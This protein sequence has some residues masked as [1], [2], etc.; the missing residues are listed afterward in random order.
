[1]NKQ[2][3]ILIIRFSAMGD[4]VLTVPVI[5]SFAAANPEAKIT[6]LTKP[7][8]HPFFD[9]IPNINLPIVELK[10]KHKGILGLR[11]LVRESHQKQRFDAII[12]LH[13]VLRTWVIGFFFRLKG[14]PVFKIDKG[15]KAKKAFLQ[16]ITTQKLPH[17]TER[18]HRVFKQAGYVFPLE[19]QQL[20]P[21]S[22][23][24]LNILN[25]TQI[26]IGLAP[27][28]AHKSKEWGLENF[29]QL[30]QQLNEEHNIQFYL[31]GGG[32][33]EVD[34]LNQFASSYK[35]VYNL[36]GKYNL[37]EEMQIISRLNLM[38]CMDSGNMHI[39]TLTGIPVISIWGGTHPN[40]GFSALY[41]PE[42][43]SI[44]PSQE[45]QQKCLYSVFGTSKPQLDESPYFC[46][47]KIKP[48]QVI[49][50]ILEIGSF[51]K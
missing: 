24:P 42:A 2:S 46:I 4:V 47:K 13:S 32:A 41:Q 28:T 6:V 31:F 18:Y 29:H 23:T 39:A 40:V 3:S 20:T 8:F 25:S 9:G 43:N 26:N 7:F 50:R 22:D 1:V 35:N 45:E 15:R 27:F 11:K 34:Q 16:D 17:S 30:V 37:R 12:D 48:Q 33:H 44:Q 49:Q 38:L 36:A 51:K 10:G 14:V 5:K 21:K 19:K